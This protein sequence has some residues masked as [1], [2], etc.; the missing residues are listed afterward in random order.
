MDLLLLSYWAIKRQVKFRVSNTKC[1]T[2]A[3]LLLTTHARQWALL[4]TSGSSPG[5]TVSTSAKKLLGGEQQKVLLCSCVNLSCFQ[6][7][8]ATHHHFS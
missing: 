4:T 6:S 1:H 7:F 5:L 2:G 8:S 3:E